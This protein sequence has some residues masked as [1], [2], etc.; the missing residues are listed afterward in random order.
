VKVIIRH[1]AN[2]APAPLYG[3]S[4]VVT[5]KP[6]TA[7]AQQAKAIVDP[8]WFGWNGGDSARS[9]LNPKSAAHFQYGIMEVQQVL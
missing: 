6:L 2:S 9:D 3:V 5:D 8:M 1:R 7:R 4:V